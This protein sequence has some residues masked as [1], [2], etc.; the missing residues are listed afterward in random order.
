M[1][2]IIVR[3]RYFLFCFLWFTMILSVNGTVRAAPELALTYKK[4]TNTKEE[5]MR[6]FMAMLLAAVLCVALLAGCTDGS[7]DK[8]KEAS[9]TVSQN[10]GDSGNTADSQET[11]KEETTTETAEAPAHVVVESLYFDAVPRDIA[12]VEK[13]INAITIPEINVEVELYPLAFS[14]ASTQVGLMISSGSQLDLVVNFRPDFL[15]L[16][17]KNM[18]L[19]ISDLLDQYGQ[20]IKE[21]A[22]DAIP[23]G[24][25]GDKLYGIPSVEKY[26][27]T[28]GLLIDKEVVDTVG[29]TKFEDLSVEELGQFL[30]KAHEAYPDTA[31]IHLTGG[32]NSVDN[33]NMLYDVD[34]LGSGSGTGGIMGIGEGEGDEI[35]NVF[36][37]EEYAEFCKTMHEWYEAGYFNKDAATSM[38][39]GQNAVTAGTAKGYFI[40]TELDMVP[41]Q[42][43][44]NGLEMVALNTRSQTLVM[45]NITSG[46]W[47]IP[48]NCKNPE[49]AMKF[50]NMMW[51]NEDII[52]LIYYGVEGLDY[53]YMEDGSGRI[54]YLEGE[55]PQTVGY[56]QWFGIYGNT[57]LRLVWDSLPADY[58]DQLEEFKNNINES[59]Q[60]KFMGYAFDPDPVKTE[61]AAVSDVISTYRT[62]L[63]CGV[64]DPETTLPQFLKDLEAAGIDKIIEANQSALDAWKAAN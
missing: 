26:G 62:S 6:K 18:V 47:S 24:Y 5:C 7:S 13:A 46:T 54:T 50:L 2:Y 15:S 8:S 30:A 38:E 29:W 53:R 40:Q 60:S 63:E 17:N 4:P 16:V 58:K 10:A 35:V 57:P 33:F 55:T 41:A 36:A 42:S 32:G 12:E 27:N 51:T 64:T 25:V 49:A 39:A 56:H 21:T 61:Y 59:N 34:Y 9:E 31:L 19:E 14:D 28:Y 23:G 48:Y 3:K 20:G 37:T 1:A 43:A 52:N 11:E 45:N 44:A 22:A